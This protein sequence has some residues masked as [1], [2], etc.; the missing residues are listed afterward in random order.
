MH[1][2]TWLG[3]RLYVYWPLRLY[4][5]NKWTASGYAR[6][7]M[8]RLQAVILSV[9]ERPQAVPQIELAAAR[10][11]LQD[12]SASGCNALRAVIKITYLDQIIRPGTTTKQWKDKT[13]HKL[14]LIEFTNILKY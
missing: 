9:I 14:R 7:D 8:I 5:F 3:R 10:L 11:L 4:Q 2:M 6:D 1:A 12:K 13:W